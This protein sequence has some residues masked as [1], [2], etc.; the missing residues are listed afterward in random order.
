MALL[1]RR[2]GAAGHAPSNFGY[3]IINRSLN[4]I[5][6]DFTSH[7]AA[8]TQEGED[9]AV[10]G[11]SLGNVITRLG[12]EALPNG[13]ARFAMLAPPNRSAALARTMLGNP[14]FRGLTREAGELLADHAFFETLPVPDTKILILA[15]DTHA[16]WLPYR[17][18][19]SDGIVGVEET[20]LDGAVHRSFDTAHTFIMNHP[21]VVRVL[22]EFLD[23]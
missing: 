18:G 19:P 7:L 14:I 9:Y 3:L 12:T 21:E 1:A 10:I 23:S 22:L 6:Q 16:P 15:G 11:H 17:G 2:L 13:L 5:A 20:R 8:N 4:A